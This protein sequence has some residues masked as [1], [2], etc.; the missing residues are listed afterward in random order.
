E[1]KMLLSKLRKA[2]GFRKSVESQ[3][4]KRDGATYTED[5]G[6]FELSSVLASGFIER[7]KERGLVVRSWAPQVDVLSRESVSRFVS[8][9][10]RMELGAG[11]N[12]M[13]EDMKVVIAVEQRERDMFVS[14]EEGERVDGV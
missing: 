1:K 13:V 6:E 11:R 9:S 10:L 14:G 4:S 3:T 8:H 5:L 2:S 12:V 7:T